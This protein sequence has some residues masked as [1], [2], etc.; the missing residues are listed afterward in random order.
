MEQQTTSMAGK[1]CE[2]GCGEKTTITPRAIPK[3]GY[4]KG[5]PYR[6][7]YRHN[8]KDLTGEKSPN[9]RG[10]RKKTNGYILIKQPQHP[11][12]GTNGYVY[13]HVL[14]A[15][16]VLGKPLP[17]SAQVHHVNEIRSDNANNN[18]VICENQSYHKL[19]HVRMRALRTCGNPNWRKCSF[20]KQHD[21]PKNLSFNPSQKTAWH[22]SCNRKYQRNR[23]AQ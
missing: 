6:F 16:K 13:E 18:L 21:D 9:W 23:K 5:Q 20:C 19:L 7:I 4:Q 15:A 17:S 1:L 8:H 2:C 12:A 3:R 14:I 11:H 10:G 22:P